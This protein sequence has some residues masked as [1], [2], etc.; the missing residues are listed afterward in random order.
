MKH[1][2]HADSMTGVLFGALLARTAGGSRVKSCRGHF[3][4]TLHKG[5]MMMP[6]HRKLT[7]GFTLIELMIVVA[8]IAIL[9]AI[10]IPSYLDY[11]TRS[12]LTEA[13]NTLSAYRVSQ[14]QYF[15]DNRTY[16]GTGLGSCGAAQPSNLKYFQ[17]NCVASSST[18]YIA[19]AVGIAGTPTAGFTFTIN[20]ANAQATTA[21]PTAKGWTT[22]AN[23]WVVRKGGSCQ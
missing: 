14:E 4:A 20:N 5:F 2:R 13:Y 10:A 23:C 21:A 9:A 12:K 22:N 18:A 11:V 3:D 16:I 1:L 19:T 15:Q 8:I 7:G 6:S 17:P